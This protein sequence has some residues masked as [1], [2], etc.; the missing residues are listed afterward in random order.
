MMVD[1]LGTRSGVVGVD[2]DGVDKEGADDGGSK[3]IL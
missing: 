1:C 3:S 2:E